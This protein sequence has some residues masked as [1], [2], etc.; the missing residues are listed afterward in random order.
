MLTRTAQAVMPEIIS[1]TPPSMRTQTNA[2]TGGAIRK[3]I[4]GIS[5]CFIVPCNAKLTGQPERSGGNKS[6]AFAVR[7]S[8]LLAACG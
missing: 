1:P 4:I 8:A 6:A 7:L 5:M 3:P 2:P